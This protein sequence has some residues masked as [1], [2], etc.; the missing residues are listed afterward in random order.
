MISWLRRLIEKPDLLSL[1]DRVEAGSVLGWLGDPRFQV[2]RSAASDTPFILPPVVTVEGGPFEMGSHLRESG[3][4]EEEYSIATNYGRHTV[5][6]AEFQIGRYAVT[7]LE[8]R[9]FIQATG[10]KPPGHWNNGE[11]P[12]GLENHPVVNVSWWDALAYCQW[13]S[14]VSGQSVRLPTEAEWEKAARWDRPRQQSYVY[15]WGD[16]WHLSCCNTFEEGLRNTASVGIYPNNASPSGALDMAGNV[17]EWTA[18]SFKTY[19]Y[20][21]GDGREDPAS[22]A[23]R[24]L[25]GGS[26]YDRQNLARCAFR[27]AARS[28]HS[29]FSIGFRVV[30]DAADVEG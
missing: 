12:G 3:A 25:R 18:S 21:P 20:Q 16:A 22:P 24:I 13:L 14:K 6:L 11:I 4:F 9:C 30:I 10:R 5:V 19:P 8:Y 15:P 23:P 28:D 17:W 27:N 1:T 2:R 7:N 26:W 29:T